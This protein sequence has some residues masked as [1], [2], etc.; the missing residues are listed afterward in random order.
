MENVFSERSFK[1]LT[2]FAALG[3]SRYAT[4]GRNDPNM[5]QPFLDYER[6]LGLGHNG[7]IV[8]FYSLRE[9]LYH[10]KTRTPAWVESDSELMLKLL[11]D[12]TR[13]GTD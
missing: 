12:S 11:C 1:T 2:G 9:E 10:T 5:L 8:N 4:V 7:N 13:T 3:H 6:G